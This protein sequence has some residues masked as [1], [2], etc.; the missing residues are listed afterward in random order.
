MSS[1]LHCDP[2]GSDSGEATGLVGPAATSLGDTSN[3]SVLH[4]DES[5]KVTS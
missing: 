4:N 2:W 1:C 3:L 5:V